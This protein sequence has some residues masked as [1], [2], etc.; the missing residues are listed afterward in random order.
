MA[1]ILCQEDPLEEEMVTHFSI[2]VRKIPWTEEPSG[3]ES[4]VP[5]RAR[6]KRSTERARTRFFPQD[7]LRYPLVYSYDSWVL[8]IYWLVQKGN[9]NPSIIFSFYI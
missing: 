2:L 7:F 6:R 1:S 8:F 3:L 9:E 4:M 5:Q